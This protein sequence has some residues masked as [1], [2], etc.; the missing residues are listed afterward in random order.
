[1]KDGFL[2]FS[3]RVK[4]MVGDTRWLAAKRDE[5][6]GTRAVI[7]KKKK[8]IGHCTWPLLLLKIFH[9]LNALTALGLNSVRSGRVLLGLIVAMEWK[10]EFSFFSYHLSSFSSPVLSRNEWDRCQM[11]LFR[12]LLQTPALWNSLITQLWE[13]AIPCTKRD[14]RS[15]FGWRESG[16]KATFSD[17][18]LNI[19]NIQ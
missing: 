3:S 16:Q 7:W 11:S 2:F 14:C 9:S 18:F 8:L 15:L 10:Q 17:S 12:G 4:F 13:G 1:M 6:L 5:F 19:L